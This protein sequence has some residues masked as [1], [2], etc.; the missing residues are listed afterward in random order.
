[1]PS[2]KALV[3]VIAL[4][5]HAMR[6][7]REEYLAE[8]FSDYL[9][10]PFTPAGLLEIIRRWVGTASECEL[11]PPKPEFEDVLGRLRQAFKT[12]LAM[13]I[14]TI[15]QLWSVVAGSDTENNRAE[16][17]KD[18]HAIVHRLTGTAGSLGFDD[19][20][21]LGSE[22]ANS[23]RPGADIVELARQVERLLQACRRDARI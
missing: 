12:R 20:S 14:S 11:K 18:L 17:S 3:P 4:T 19:I 5:A 21:V 7:A 13:D 10:K 2:E 22:L 16:A 6:G 8:G 15:E 23:A 9:S 1:M